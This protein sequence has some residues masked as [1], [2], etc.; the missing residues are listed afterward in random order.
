MT[1]WPFPKIFD[2]LNFRYKKGEIKL[3]SGEKIQVKQFFSRKCP[4]VIN[5]TTHDKNKKEIEKGAYQTEKFDFINQDA[6]EY[7]VPESISVFIRKKILKKFKKVMAKKDLAALSLCFHTIDLEDKG[8]HKKAID[9]HDKICRKF[10]S[11]AAIYNFCRSGL[12][13]PPQGGIYLKLVELEKKYSKNMTKVVDEFQTY[14]QG[15]IKKHPQNIYVSP[16]WTDSN[17]LEEIKERLMFMT[18]KNDIRII[19]IYGRGGRIINMIEKT[20]EKSEIKKIFKVSYEYYKFGKNN[21]ITA[22]LAL[23]LPEVY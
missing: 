3:E 13:E 1:G 14:F 9:L 8:K 17:L 4:V 19:K 15:L 11:G 10:E 7:A 5:L 20:C 6:L 21:G 23:K 2:K 22:Y 18:E 16:S 12:F